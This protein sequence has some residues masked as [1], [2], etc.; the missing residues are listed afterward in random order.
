MKKTLRHHGRERFCES[1]LRKPNEKSH[2][3]KLVEKIALPF[4]AD[5]NICNLHEEFYKVC[6]RKQDVYFF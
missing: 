2:V 4:M 5:Y 1:Q 3:Q 6:I